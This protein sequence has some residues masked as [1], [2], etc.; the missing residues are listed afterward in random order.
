MREEMYRTLGVDLTQVPSIGT[1]LVTV[2]ATEVGENLKQDFPSASA[3]ASWL[4]FC[5]AHEISGGRVLSR[6]TRKV[7]SR[8]AE[9]FRMSAQALHKS[10]SYLG[11]FYRRMRSKL[12]APKAITAAAHKL[13]RI[14]YH[15]VTMKEPYN[16]SV[17]DKMNE[18][19]LKQQKAKLIKKAK[20]MG[21]VLVPLA[22]VPSEVVP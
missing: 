15:L 10:Q 11:D 4:G 6:K 17:F 5:P 3:F 1:S 7:K 9:A 21:L 22:A 18:R 8:L 13:A 20:A 16:E 14:V 2:L 19:I 12:G